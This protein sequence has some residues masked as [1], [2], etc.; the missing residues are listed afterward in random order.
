MWI[1]N[2]KPVLKVIKLVFNCCLILFVWELLVQTSSD[3][4]AWF[5]SDIRLE[6][7]AT[8]KTENVILY[9]SLLL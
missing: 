5:Y 1:N 2:S 3:F 6:V 8:L 4:T 9:D 7:I